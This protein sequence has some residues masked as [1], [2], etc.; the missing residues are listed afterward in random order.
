M[1]SRKIQCLSLI[2]FP[3]P[4]DF[5]HTFPRRA[6]QIRLRIATRSPTS[7][8]LNVALRQRSE[9]YRIYWQTSLTALPEWSVSEVLASTAVSDPEAALVFSVKNPGTVEI[10]ELTLT[11]LTP[12]QALGNRS[13]DGNLLPSSSLPIGIAAPWAV[14]GNGAPAGAYVADPSVPGPSGLPSL[15]MTTFSD[16]GRPVAQLTAPFEGRPGT[17]HTFSFWARAAHNGHEASIRVGPPAEQLHESPWSKTVKLTDEWKRYDFTLTL[18]PSPDG[19]YLAR[20]N[21]HEAGVICVDQ[22]MIE[23]T[24]T[25]S[26]FKPSDDVELSAVSEAN[27]G[28]GF[29]DQPLAYRVAAHGALNRVGG[30]F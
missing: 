22:L 15:R 30:R 23:V 7:T 13:F 21:T 18:P 12:A 29:A 6:Y 20:I 2:H 5:S 3:K 16:T 26:K 4:S 10:D 28:L 19:F 8:P 24:D 27:F 25:V 11:Y 17:P 9:P 1:L 14:G